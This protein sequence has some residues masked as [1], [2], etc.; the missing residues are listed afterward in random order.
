[1][2]T[3]SWDVVRSRMLGPEVLPAF[4]GVL[5][6]GVILEAQEGLMG[7]ASTDW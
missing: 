1:M 2:R 3:E 5:R 6:I 4:V 7:F